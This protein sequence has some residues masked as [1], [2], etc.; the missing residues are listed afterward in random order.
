MVQKNHLYISINFFAKKNKIIT[1]FLRN[2]HGFDIDKSFQCHYYKHT[3]KSMLDIYSKLIP[4]FLNKVRMPICCF[5]REFKDKTGTELSD[6]NTFIL[7]NRKN[8][9]R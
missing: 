6:D 5:E 1:L 4:S 2:Y 8:K 7:D 9:K 3:N